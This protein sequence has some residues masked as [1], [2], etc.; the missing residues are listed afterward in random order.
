[1]IRTLIAHL[2]LVVGTTA[3]ADQRD[4]V[5]PIGKVIDL[6]K[7]MKAKGDAAQK[8]EATKFAAFEQW[9]QDQQ[10][11]KTDEIASAD[12]SIE[13]LN[14]GILKHKVSIEALSNRIQELEEDVGR[15]TKDT[16]SV[17]EIRTK[18]KADYDTTAQDFSETLG[19]LDEAIAVLARRAAKVEQP[20]SESWEGALLQLT[21]RAKIPAGAKSALMAFLQQAQPDVE[22]MPDSDLYKSAPQA[23]AYEFQSGGI[24]DMLKKLKS[25]FSQKKYET[26]M[27]EKNAQHAFEQMVQQL[28]DSIENANHEISK[29]TAT[30]GETEQAKAEAEGDLA[31][32]TAD[33]AEDK[34]YLLDTEALC[35]L[36]KTD[37]DSR[38]KLRSSEL[39]AINK[40]IEIISGS[41]VAGAGERHLPSALQLRRGPRGTALAQLR[42]DH[43][44]AAP[45]QKRIADFLAERAHSSGSKLLMMVSER[46][47]VDPF[48][49]VK[50]LIKDLI[51]KLMEEA[52]AETEH[53]GW[54]DTELT[55]NKQTR[56]YRTEDV[57]KLTAEIEDLNAELADL[58]QRVEELTQ[59]IAELEKEMAAATEDRA[60]SKANNEQTTADAKAAQEAVQNAIAILKAYYAKSAEATAFAQRQPAERESTAFVKDQATAKPAEDAPETFDKPYQGMLP[61]GGSVV[62]FLEV[63]LTDFNRLEAET[64]SSEAAELAEYKKYMAESEKDKAL[65]ENE[66]KHKGARIK[67]QTSALHQ[68]EE[69][70]S[71][72]QEQLSA[73]VAYYEKL[74]PE[75]VDSGITYEQ[76]V[77]N[78]EAEIQSLEEALKILTGVEWSPD[79]APTA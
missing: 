9:C 10:R 5:T 57:N 64:V 71:I 2:V 67:A 55:T 51:V 65:K 37:F 4:G 48:T 47:A 62:D 77:K 41:A 72:K 29:K 74:K 70:L 24:V 17:R 52:T 33:R 21:K 53:K 35:K 60:A 66:I 46:V 6:L 68:A 27:E 23:A 42:S 32:I 39:E 78:R 79:A 14:A 63:I 31:Q 40:A 73:A 15:W 8:E 25:E 3:E 28:A 76:R 69:M 36:K 34:T 1:M 75:C 20:E 38:Q 22:A 7:E 19:A 58:A 54:C 30:R 16:A 18:E 49:K 44:Q 50:K 61:E 11:I 43:D 56:E 12:A 45:L 13:E 59:A 26:E